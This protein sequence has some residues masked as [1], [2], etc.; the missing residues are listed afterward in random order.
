MLFFAASV[1]GAALSDCPP[2]ESPPPASNWQ[3]DKA[4]VSAFFHQGTPEET[5]DELIDAIVPAALKKAPGVTAAPRESFTLSWRGGTVEGRRIRVDI[6]NRTGFTLWIAV[7]P[8][9]ATRHLLLECTEPNGNTQCEGRMGEVAMNGV[10]VPPMIG[11]NGKPLMLPSSCEWNSTPVEPLDIR[12][13][14]D[15]ALMWARAPDAE[16]AQ[17]LAVQRYVSSQ[18]E[19][20]SVEGIPFRRCSIAG[21]QASCLQTETVEGEWLR[22]GYT[23]TGFGWCTQPKRGPPTSLCK[24]VFLR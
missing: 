2:A 13:Q 20:A 8:W 16:A 1:Y 3:C 11:H 19:G 6:P 18:P 22:I 15:G 4:M 7:I 23:D 5:A 9:D 17:L 10:P 24:S 14:A 12:C 21:N